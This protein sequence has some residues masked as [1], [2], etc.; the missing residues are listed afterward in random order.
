MTEK[1]GECSLFVDTHRCGKLL[2]STGPRVEQAAEDGTSGRFRLRI[3]LVY[4]LRSGLRKTESGI[5]SL[6]L[7]QEG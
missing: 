1:I 3:L 6:V 2:V 4:D 5:D 7:Y